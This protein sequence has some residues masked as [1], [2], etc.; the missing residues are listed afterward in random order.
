MSTDDKPTAA[1][2]GEQID[3][4]IRRHLPGISEMFPLSRT[5]IVAVIQDTEAIVREDE[6]A[7]CRKEETE[8]W[9]RRFEEIVEILHKEGP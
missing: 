1:L 8:R 5:Q 2:T 9:I 3:T 4:L 7:K 6:R